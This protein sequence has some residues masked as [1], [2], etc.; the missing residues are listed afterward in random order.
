M[1]VW[2]GSVSSRHVES[3]LYRAS[4]PPLWQQFS[5][6]SS[7]DSTQQLKM[8]YLDYHWLVLCCMESNNCCKNHHQKK[9]KQEQKERRC[10]VDQDSKRF[11]ASLIQCTWCTFTISFQSIGNRRMNTGYDMLTQGICFKISGSSMNEVRLC[12]LNKDDKTFCA[13]RGARTHDP[14][15]KSLMLYRLS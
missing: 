5:C 15:I 14:E 3:R 4:T 13:Q 2:F 12:K 1:W 10:S 9:R 6:L 8:N 7:S 11:C